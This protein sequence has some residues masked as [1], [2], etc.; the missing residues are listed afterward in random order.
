MSELT[1]FVSPKAADQKHCYSCSSLLHFSAKQC[2]RCGAQQPET[3]TAPVLLGMPNS[4]QS[5]GLPPNH[6]YCRGC[7]SA[8]HQSAST[9][10]KCGAPQQTK[11][12]NSGLSS[13][14]RVTAAI[15]ALLLGGF[16]AHKFYL[17]KIFIG[18][19]YLLF[20]WTFI[21]ALIAIFEGIYY[22]TQTDEEF[23]RRNF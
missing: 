15:L 10:P 17:G 3:P 21:P 14:K 22:L 2:P 6:V 9:C 13:G 5:Q 19:L 16:G 7:G 8:I 11:T 12:E 20:C 1:P 4:M 23:D 18:L